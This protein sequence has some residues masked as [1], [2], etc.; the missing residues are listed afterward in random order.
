MTNAVIDGLKLYAAYG[1]YTNCTFSNNG[2]YPVYYTE[3]S[4]QPFHSN[5][6]FTGNGINLI[7]LSGGTYTESK[8]ITKDGTEYLLL[9]NIIVGKRAEVRR[10]TIDKG[11]TINISSG[12]GIKVG[13]WTDYHNGG[14]LYAVGN[15]DSLI[16]FKPYSGIAG[17]WNGIYFDDRSDWNGAT[18]QLIYC[19]IEKAN[20]YNIYFENTGSVTLDHCIISNAITDGLRLYGA[21]GSYTNCTFSNNGRYP[22]YYTEWT[23]QPTHYN[24]TYIGN[25]INLIALSGGTYTESRSITKDGTE[26][27]LLDNIIVGKRADVRRLTIDKGITVNI[28]SGKGIQIGQWTD[29][30]NGGELY[31]VGNADSLISFKPYSGITGDWNGI[32]FDPR[33]NWG[34]ATSNL[35]YCNIEKGNTYNVYTES[36][37]Q[38]TINH[39]KFTFSNGNGLV[40]SNSNLNIRNSSFTNN[41]ANGIYFDGTGTATLGNADSLTCNLYNNGTYAVYNNSS[42]DINARYNYWGS[43]DS[44]MITLKIYDKGDNSAKGRVYFTPF[45]QLPS[46]F[47]ANTIMSGTIKYANTG[48]NP[49]KNATMV[50]KNFSD[51]VIATTTS[52]TSGVYAFS[53]FPSGN[54]KMSITPAAPWG[55]VNSTDA[56]AILN[57]FAQLTTLTGINQAAADVNNSHTINGTDALFV[58]KRYSGMISS[59]PSGDYLHHSDTLIVNGN[60]VTNNLKMICYG[61]VNASNTPAKKSSTSVGLVHEGSIIA[62][63]FTEYDFPVRLKTG[64]QLGAISFGLYYPSQYLEIIGARLV[65]NVSGFSWTAT[66]GLFKMAWCDINS[67]T[68]NDDG[69]AIILRIKTKDISGL[70][71]EI[72]KDI[73]SDCEFADPYAIPNDMEIVSI[74]KITSTLLGI[75]TNNKKSDL[76][77]YPNPVNGKSKISFT[78]DK[79]GNIQISLIDIIGHQLSEITNSNYLAG[80]HKIDL[81]S[82]ELKP[83]IYFL[84]FT[85]TSNGIVN[86]DIIKLVVSY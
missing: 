80:M 10:L 22:V 63:S 77:V 40:I 54:Y 30:Y 15:A 83:G 61:D 81:Q 44:T 41:A 75:Q 74:P 7:A 58:M 68:I 24:N 3:W 82:S 79:P 12:K 29:Y 73:T 47:T 52:N 5:N 18:N 35:T 25:V 33:S 17:D 49:I 60:L 39:S 56:L 46:L 1:S 9:D 42:A 11:I 4:S 26:Y 76:S 34:G 66:Q 6:I 21:Y 57:H 31:A 67:L 50:I 53:A 20:D 86:S 2:R 14:E 37:A 71:S 19:K 65:N 64:M 59:F 8:S 70:T 38:P 43:C 72:A 48:A 45:A 23:S 36:T 78:L 84:K 32:Y 16:T 69:I 28:S 13:Q 27:L 62:E 55:G 85:N 51:T